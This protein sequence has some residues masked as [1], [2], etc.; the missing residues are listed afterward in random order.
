M[1]TRPKS[2][3]EAPRGG[4]AGGEGLEQPDGRGARVHARAEPGRAQLLRQGA[5]D[6]LGGGLVELLRVQPADVVG[7]ED[8]VGDRHVPSLPRSCS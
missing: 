7:L 8:A 2:T 3:V 5:A 1:G 6:A 4:G